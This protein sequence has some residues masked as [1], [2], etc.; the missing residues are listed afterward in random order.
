[1]LP[2][3]CG[4]ILITLIGIALA[5]DLRSTSKKIQKDARNFLLVDH[6][7]DMANLILQQITPSNLVEELKTNS[8]DDFIM[9]ADDKIGE[10]VYEILYDVKETPIIIHQSYQPFLTK[11]IIIDITNSFLVAHP[12]CS[13]VLKDCYYNKIRKDIMEIEQTEQEHIE[14][15]KQFG[16]EPDGDPVLHDREN[17]NDKDNE[18]EELSEN[19]F[20]D[21][22]IKDLLKTGVVEI[23]DDLNDNY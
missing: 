12:K 22:P 9:K 4:I 19:Y 16:E 20:D 2:I 18:S 7:E 21:Q 6:K 11:D 8:Y 14:L 13:Q 1:M 15:L 5:I 3:I 23:Y 10:K 17:L